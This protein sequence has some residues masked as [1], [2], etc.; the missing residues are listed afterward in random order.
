M[1]CN[2]AKYWAMCRTG[3]KASLPLNMNIVRKN[4]EIR[5][6]E[7]VNHQLKLS[8]ADAVL[9]MKETSVTRKTVTEDEILAEMWEDDAA[10]AVRFMQPESLNNEFIVKL[11]QKYKDINTL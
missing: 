1:N 3:T 7:E 9:S 6:L 11:H 5:K 8:L 10:N 4:N 2:F